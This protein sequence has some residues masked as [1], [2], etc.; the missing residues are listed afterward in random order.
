[1]RDRNHIVEEHLSAVPTPKAQVLSGSAVL[2][3]GLGLASTFNFTYNIAAARLL[4]PAAFGHASVIYTLLTL[5]SAVALSFQIVSAKVVVQQASAQAKGAAYSKL[6]RSAWLGG[7]L[8]GGLLVLLR[9]TIVH[10]LNLPGSNLVVWLGV[11]VAFYVPLEAR[12]GYLIGVLR[13]RHLA[14]NLV[15]EAFVRLCGTLVLVRSGWGV[16]GVVIATA[17]AEV[18]AYFFAAPSLSDTAEAIEVE[19]PHAFR[20]ALQAIV[21]FAGQVIINNGDI[22]LVKHFFPPADAGLYAAVALVGRVVFAFSWAVVNSMFPI[23]AGTCKRSRKSHGVLGTALALVSAIGVI[24][25]VALR[26]APAQLWTALLGSQFV[27]V[28]NHNISNLLVLYAATTAL[29]SISVVL[30]AYEMSYRIANTSWVQLAFSG[31]LIGGIYLFHASLYQVILVQMVMLVVLIL[32]VSA[33]FLVR[34]FN[35]PEQ[36][37]K[38]GVG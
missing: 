37:A 30:I 28:G 11:A 19:V 13:F 10:Y 23:A 17:G 7:L 29:F 36:A 9:G 16:T 2:L 24:F 5:M 32:V 4:G 27:A 31:V 25:V 38:A 26:L 20:E 1:M 21:F 12:R 3:T 22:V 33:P 15:L 35:Y 14:T 34:Q 8:S 6:H 18:G